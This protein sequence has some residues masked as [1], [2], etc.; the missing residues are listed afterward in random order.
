MNRYAF[1]RE[2]MRSSI[3]VA[4]DQARL[5]AAREVADAWSPRARSS[6]RPR[7]ARSSRSRRSPST[8]RCRSRRSALP[9]PMIAGPAH[10]RCARGARRPRSRPVPRRAS[11]RARPRCAASRS[12]RISRFASS[13]SSSWPVSFHQPSTMCGSTRSPR[14][15]SAWIASVISSSSRHDGS[16]ARA[17]SKIDGREHVDAD[18]REVRRRVLGLL[19][20]PLRPGRRRAPRRRSARGRARG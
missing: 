16:I 12:S 13:M 15:I 5:H 6:A 19:D 3:D 1:G 14:S 10:G 11:R 17:A 7:S 9:A 18:E 2:L 4:A 20:Q 8:G